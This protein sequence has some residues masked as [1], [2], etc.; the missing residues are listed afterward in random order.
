MSE[1]SPTTGD[2]RAERILALIGQ[3]EGPSLEYK[4]TIRDPQQLSQ[5]IGAFANTDGGTIIVGVQEPDKIVGCEASRIRRTFLSAMDSLRPAIE[6][7]FLAIQTGDK[8]IVAISISRHSELVMASGGAFTRTGDRLQAM[9][10]AEIESRLRSE[11]K[12]ISIHSIAEAIAAQTQMIAALQ[13]KLQDASSLKSKMV[14]Y[15]IGG[16]IGAVMGAIAT[17]MIG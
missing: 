8:W 12:E 10:A 7:E 16:L 9:S 6:P 11:S 17:L 3:P 1:T 2:R 14:D 5:L 15:L 4:T 13:L